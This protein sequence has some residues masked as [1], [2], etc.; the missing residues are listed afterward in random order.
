LKCHWPPNRKSSNSLLE[1]LVQH[2]H[3]LP[4]LMTLLST[5]LVSQL[6]ATPGNFLVPEGQLFSMKRGEPIAEILQLFQC[7]P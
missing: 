2:L 5:F 7:L 1:C 4:V 3:L 6:Q